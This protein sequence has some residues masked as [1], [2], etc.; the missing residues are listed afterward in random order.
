MELDQADWT[1]LRELL[2]WGHTNYPRGPLRTSV[3]GLARRLGMHRNT[4]RVRLKALRGGGVLRGTV[5]EP[6][7]HVL[8]LGR[9]GWFFLRARLPDVQEV[10][11]RLASFPEVAEVAVLVV[12]Y[13]WAFA[14][15]WHEGEALPGAFVERLRLALGA[16][17]ALE[18]YNTRR[19]PVIPAAQLS[20]LDGR[21]V[22]AL[23]EE[24]GRSMKAVARQLRVTER[25]VERR[26]RR[27]IDAGAGAMLPVLDLG[28]VD[29]WTLAEYV[30][31]D[32]HP[33][34]AASLAVAFPERILGPFGPGICPNV[35]VPMRS[36]A[37]A[38][39]RRALATRLPGLSNLTLLLIRD[40]RFLAGFEPWLASH[41]GSAQ[42]GAPEGQ[43]HPLA[44]RPA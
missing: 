9:S 33:G 40:V 15:A 38:E 14:H 18:D 1:I 25:T 28:A 3:E 10:E 5:F 23:R 8:G 16:E 42:R 4:V 35:A 44:F 36:L 30:A 20:R 7:P 12:G 19:F 41:V 26:A 6:F 43:V 13:D 29:G 31:F 34:A 17:A 24:P 32:R 21:L 27:L 22:K 11:R 2:Q 39:R 37:E